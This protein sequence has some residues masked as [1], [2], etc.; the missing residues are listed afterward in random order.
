MVLVNKAVDNT[1]WWLWDGYRFV[2]RVGGALLDEKLL[3]GI[4]DTTD[5]SLNYFR[6]QPAEIIVDPRSVLYEPSAPSPPSAPAA[7]GPATVPPAPPASE[8]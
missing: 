4:Q 6:L 2:Q 5:R 7:A 3:N 8:K 1:Q